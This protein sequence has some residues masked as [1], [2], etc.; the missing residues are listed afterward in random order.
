MTVGPKTAKLEAV[1][2]RRQKK[3][4]YCGILALKSPSQNA[5]RRAKHFGFEATLFQIPTQAGL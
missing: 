3:F 4:C 5:P 1:K 2:V